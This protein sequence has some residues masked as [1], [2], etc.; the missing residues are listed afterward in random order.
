MA[1]CS[2]VE[3]YTEWQVSNTLIY[4]SFNY[5]SFYKVCLLW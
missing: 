1:F 4:D 2:G 5:I 3:F